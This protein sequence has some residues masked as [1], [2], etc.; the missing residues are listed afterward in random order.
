MDRRK[1]P[2]GR[3]RRLGQAVPVGR[4]EEGADAHLLPAYPTSG[5][6]CCRRCTRSSTS[7]GGSRCR[8]WRRSPRS[9]SSPPAEVHGHGH[10][11]TRSTGSS[12][13]AS[14][15]FRCAGRS[16]ARSAGRADHRPP[17][18]RSSA[19]SRRDHGDG[20]F[21]LVELECLGSCGT[22]PV[23]LV[24]DVLYED[25]TPESIDQLIASLPN[26]PHEFKDPIV[27]WEEGKRCNLR[28]QNS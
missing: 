6:C 8:R 24:N 20:R 11:S 18:G 19:S 7:T 5:R 3:G 14:T 27:T 23:A 28:L 25:L 15:W 17:A 12:P 21:T 4:A 13:R 26:D 9:W 16:R 2:H 10:R 22:A 1:P